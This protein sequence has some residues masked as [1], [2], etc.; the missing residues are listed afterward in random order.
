MSVP[1]REPEASPRF[2]ATA[3]RSARSRSEPPLDRFRGVLVGGRHELLK[4]MAFALGFI[5]I[6]GAF[7]ARAHLASPDNQFAADTRAAIGAFG[8]TLASGA[9][10]LTGAAGGA[11]GL[12][13]Q[14]VSAAIRGGQTAAPVSV[15]PAPAAA[16]ASPSP[17]PHAP[18]STAGR[19]PVVAFASASHPV[20]TAMRPQSSVAGVEKREAKAQAPA[21]ARN[22]GAAPAG[23]GARTLDAPADDIGHE[24]SKAYY[25]ILSFFASGTSGF[26]TEAENWMNW[27][28]DRLDL[29]RADAGFNPQDPSSLLQSMT[30]V[31]AAIAVAGA[32]LFL[33]VVLGFTF[34]VK[35]YLRNAGRRRRARRSGGSV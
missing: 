6:L 23:T 18:A 3:D 5:L 20:Q 29:T 10:A 34:S 9:S 8:G 1:L 16:V 19:R 14:R 35:D 25:G 30:G 24:F 21:P 7:A 32:L 12:A 2:A 27:L 11:I 28:T 15:A 17:A 13:A 4:T 33:V 22:S 31:R 26:R